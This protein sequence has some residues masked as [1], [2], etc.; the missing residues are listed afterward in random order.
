MICAV[1]PKVNGAV[2][3]LASRD[4]ANEKDTPRAGQLWGHK[5]P[6]TALLCRRGGERAATG[7]LKS[8]GREAVRVRIPPPASTSTMVSFATPAPKK[9]ERAKGNKQPA[10]IRLGIAR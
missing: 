6:V 3:G 2:V 5:A 7:D 1:T 10:Q 4:P 8:P 9:V